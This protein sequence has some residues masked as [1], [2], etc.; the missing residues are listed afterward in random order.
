MEGTR[1]GIHVNSESLAAISV[2]PRLL[3][4]RRGRGQGLALYFYRLVTPLVSAVGRLLAGQE[5]QQGSRD[6]QESSAIPGTSSAE[7]L[8]LRWEHDI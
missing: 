8:L 3:D 6:Y 7:D 5:G 2:A 1:I 4:G